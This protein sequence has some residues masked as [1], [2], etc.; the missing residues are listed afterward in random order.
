MWD[1]IEFNCCS[2]KITA[3]LPS[4]RVAYV[5]QVFLLQAAA[6]VLYLVTCYMPCPWLASVVPHHRVTGTFAEQLLLFP[7]R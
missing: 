7:L 1:A 6:K 5:E 3:L 2:V 4:G